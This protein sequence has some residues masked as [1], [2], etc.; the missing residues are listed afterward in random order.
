[1]AIIYVPGVI[2]YDAA[3]DVIKLT[4]FWT[5]WTFLYCHRV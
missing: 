2:D 5:F 4:Y 3:S 1:M